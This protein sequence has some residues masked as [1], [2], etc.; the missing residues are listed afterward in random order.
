MAGLLVIHSNCRTE[1]SWEGERKN[2]DI[3]TGREQHMAQI[4]QGRLAFV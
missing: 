1:K 4:V 2:R 3:G